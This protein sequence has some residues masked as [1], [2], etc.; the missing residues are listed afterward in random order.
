MSETNE[1]K[2]TKKLKKAFA[3]AELGELRE[4]L[5]TDLEKIQEISIKDKLLKYQGFL[6]LSV[7]KVD[8]M[9]REMVQE[10][11]RNRVS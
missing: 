1:P 11:P 3:A 2:K 9:R 4:K 10:G 8:G 7:P 6:V 5:T